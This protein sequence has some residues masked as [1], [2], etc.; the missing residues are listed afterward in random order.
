[1][2]LSTLRE[3]LSTILLL[4]VVC[5]LVVS[6][7]AIY[8]RFRNGQPSDK[9]RHR[10][11]GCLREFT[12]RNLPR[13]TILSS[14]ANIQREKE[15]KIRNVYEIETRETKVSGNDQTIG[16]LKVGGDRA[17]HRRR[18]LARS[19][20]NKNAGVAQKVTA[21]IGRNVNSFQRRTV[22][23]G[24]FPVEISE[25]GPK[26]CCATQIDQEKPPLHFCSFPCY[27]SIIKRSR[28]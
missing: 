8:S 10:C 22:H 7:V 3:V 17:I 5:L 4:V 16:K 25:P 14:S 28:N 2:S 23:V 18:I 21:R 26:Q 6:L 1:M 19:R 27:R 9:G 24:S 12:C 20:R 13:K 11:A 15:N